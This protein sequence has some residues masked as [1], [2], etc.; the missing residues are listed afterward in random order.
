MCC[1]RGNRASPLPPAPPPAAWIHYNK[2][3]AFVG[4]LS[5]QAAAVAADLV[6]A[7]QRC[8]LTAKVA[9]KVGGGAGVRSAINV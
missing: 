4:R 9:E 7:W 6:L 5:R 8:C 3:Q 2:K 1:I